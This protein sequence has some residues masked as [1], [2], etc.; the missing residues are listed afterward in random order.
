MLKDIILYLLVNLVILLLSLLS[1]EMAKI[2]Q[3]ATVLYEVLKNVVPGSKF[4][5]KV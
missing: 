5:P 2:Y 3:I 4:E 1:E